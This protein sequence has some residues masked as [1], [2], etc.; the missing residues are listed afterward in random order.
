LLYGLGEN[1]F[2]LYRVESQGNQTH[3]PQRLD[4]FVAEEHLAQ[5]VYEVVEGL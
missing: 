4:D 1:Q 3:L 5:V 2:R